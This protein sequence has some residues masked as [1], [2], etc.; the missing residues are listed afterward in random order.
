MRF[1]CEHRS[2]IRLLRA[3]TPRP[4]NPRPNSNRCSS[5]FRRIM[6]GGE[7]LWPHSIPIDFLLYNVTI[8]D[9]TVA[10]FLNS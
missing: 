4:I 1:R 3:A 8:G 6:S 7:L 9:L 2:H 10:V 5:N